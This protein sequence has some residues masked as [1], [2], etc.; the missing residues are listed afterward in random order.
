MIGGSRMEGG[1][2][3]SYDAGTGRLFVSIGSAVAPSLECGCF[4]NASGINGVWK[5]FPCNTVDF[6]SF[7]K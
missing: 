3:Y 1:S 7:F 6:A 4:Q 5:S 2:Y